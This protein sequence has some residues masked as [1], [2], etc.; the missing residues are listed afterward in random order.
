[1]SISARDITGVILAGGLARRMGGV[2]K[3]LQPFLGQ[4]LVEHALSRL[5]PQVATVGINANRHLDQY[6]A[7]GV[8]VWPDH[9]T[10]FEGPLAG[11]AAALSQCNTPY[12]LTVPCDT[13]RFPLDLAARL[14]Q[15]LQEANADIAMACAVEPQASGE[16]QIRSQPVFCLLRTSLLNSL[17]TFMQ[18]GGRKIDAWTAQHHTALVS[19]DKP[20]DDPHGFFNINTLQQLQSFATSQP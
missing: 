10:H 8:A 1:M 15:A 19:F 2:D 17:N 6:R 7:M 16:S 3:G 12:L 13:P 4:T 14:G 20:G 5:R 18:N 11:F 9:N